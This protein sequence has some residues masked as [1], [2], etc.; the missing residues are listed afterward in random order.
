M[1]S[2]RDPEAPKGE[3]GGAKARVKASIFSHTRC[4]MAVGELI[5]TH[6]THLYSFFL[7]STRL[8]HLNSFFLISTHFVVSTLLP[9]E[10]IEDRDD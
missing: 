6:L 2:A 7:I 9:R 10:K 3:P 4:T 8:T 1:T 5:S